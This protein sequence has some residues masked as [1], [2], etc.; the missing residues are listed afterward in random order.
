[1]L[2]GLLGIDS[3]LAALI[4]SPSLSSKGAVL[5]HQFDDA[6]LSNPPSARVD[7]TTSRARTN[8]LQPVVH[9]FEAALRKVPGS[10]SDT[11]LNPE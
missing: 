6:E 4:V 9:R 8:S 10:S 1:M 2:N 7:V 3:N 5:I 11:S